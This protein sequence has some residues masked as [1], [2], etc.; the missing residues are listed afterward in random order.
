MIWAI[1][2]STTFDALNNNVLP[3][4][5]ALR[6]HGMQPTQIGL[7]LLDEGEW[8]ARW[9]VTG[10]EELDKGQ[11]TMFY[12]STK[13]AELAPLQGFK[14]GA[15][16]EKSWWDPRIWMRNHPDMLNPGMEVYTVK[17]FLN[18]WAR[19]TP[20]F[21][22]PVDPKLFTGTVFEGPDK[23]D[24]TDRGLREDALV[25]V[26]PIVEGIEREWRFFIVNN[27]I[28]TGSLY[29]RNGCRIIREP[30]SS[31]VYKIAQNLANKW[32]PFHTIVMDI[33]ELRNGDFRVVEFNCVNSSGFYNS[34]IGKIVEALGG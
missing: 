28:I 14:P 29:K 23:E 33:C 31:S 30:I 19:L 24:F 11:P 18:E 1:Q 25:C 8:P 32:L 20:R 4:L 15:Y 13:L 10:I 27:Q 7:A 5:E 12:G 9:V 21:V 6:S 2:D 17:T 22:K 3:L 34:D 16:Y 26:G